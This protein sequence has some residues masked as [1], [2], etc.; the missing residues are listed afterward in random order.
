MSEDLEEEQIQ[1]R[2]KVKETKTIEKKTKP[3]TN[4]TNT[5]KKK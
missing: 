5:Q 2:R 1:S 3:G 4:H